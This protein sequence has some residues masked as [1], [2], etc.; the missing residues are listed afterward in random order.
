MAGIETLV[1]QILRPDRRRLLAGLGAAV[2]ASRI[3]PPVSAP[4]QAGLAPPA[5][6]DPPSEY[7]IKPDVLTWW[8]N[9]APQEAPHITGGGGSLE[10]TLSN[11][12]PVPVTLNWRG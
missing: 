3:L 4:T 10:F 1:D 5:S 7:P 6:V 12:L 11:D 8:A 2:L 9:G